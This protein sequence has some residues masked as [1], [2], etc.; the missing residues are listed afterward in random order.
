MQLLG[1]T[2]TYMIVKKNN[3]NWKAFWEIAQKH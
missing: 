2:K 1:F 3:K